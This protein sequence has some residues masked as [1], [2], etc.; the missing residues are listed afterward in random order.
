[1]VWSRA[2]RS[3]LSRQATDLAARGHHRRAYLVLKRLLEIEEKLPRGDSA[4]IHLQLALVAPTPGDAIRHLELAAASGSQETQATAA[5]RIGSTLWRIG[6]PKEGEA[7]LQTAV[8]LRRLLGVQRDLIGALGEHGQVLAVLGRADEAQ[9][10]FE[11]ASRLSR[12]CGDW[13]AELQWGEVWSQTKNLIS[14]G[15]SSPYGY[16]GFDIASAAAHMPEAEL[17]AGLHRLAFGYRQIGESDMAQGAIT[18][19]L[20]LATRSAG[21]AWSAVRNQQAAVDFEFGRVDCALSGHREAH[22]LADQSGLHAQG[23]KF[24]AD[25][26]FVEN[27]SRASSARDT[28]TELSRK[29]RAADARGLA[30]WAE[31]CLAKHAIASGD[32]N[33]ARQHLGAAVDYATAAND[34]RALA[35]AAYAAAV[36]AGAVGE[37]KIAGLADLAVRSNAAA[38]RYAEREFATAT[39]GDLLEELRLPSRR[40]SPDIA[41]RCAEAAAAWAVL[42]EPSPTAESGSRTG[43]V[44][45]AMTVESWRTLEQAERLLARRQAS[46]AAAVASAAL[47]SAERQDDHAGVFWLRETLI[48]ALIEMGELARATTEASSLQELAATPIE[49]LAVAKTFALIAEQE[50]RIA[51]GLAELDG[52]INQTATLEPENELLQVIVS[53]RLL[54]AGMLADARGRDF[55]SARSAMDRRTRLTR[56]EADYHWILE[57]TDPS[58]HSARATVWRQRARIAEASGDIDA[59][60][61]YAREALAAIRGTSD[62]VLQGSIFVDCARW[63]RLVDPSPSQRLASRHLFAAAS[64]I[65]ERHGDSRQLARA[66]EHLVGLDHEEGRPTDYDTEVAPLLEKHGDVADIAANMLTKGRVLGGRE[67]AT[68]IAQGVEWLRRSRDVDRLQRA[69]AELAVCAVFGETSEIKATDCTAEIV[70]SVEATLAKQATVEDR[71]R[72]MEQCGDAYGLHALC[73]FLEERPTDSF[74]AAELGRAR[75]LADA[76]AAKADDRSVAELR[77]RQTETITA[78]RAAEMR[79]DTVTVAQLTLTKQQ[80]EH[81]IE[82]AVGRTSVAEPCTWETVHAHLDSQT[83]LLTYTSTQDAILGFCAT[84]EIFMAFNVAETRRTVE[85]RTAEL[86]LAIR[87]RLSRYPHGH[88]LYELLLGPVAQ[89]LGGRDVAVVADGA[90]QQLPWPALLTR[91]PDANEEKFQDHWSEPNDTR[92]G[93]IGLTGDLRHVQPASASM[94][95][96][97]PMMS[98]MGPISFRLTDLPYALHDRAFSSFPSVSAFLAARTRVEKTSVRTALIVADPAVREGETV[99]VT[100]QPTVLRSLQHAASEGREVGRVYEPT[101]PK[102]LPDFYDGKVV[103]A[104]LRQ[105]ATRDEVLRLL[106]EVPPDVL[107]VACHGVADRRDPL[108]SCLVLTGE[109]PQASRLLV[110]DVL[111]LDLRK[112][113]VVLS[114]CDSAAGRLVGGEGIIG[115]ARGFLMAGAPFVCASLWPVVDEEVPDLMVRFHRRLKDGQPAARALRRAQLDW[116]RQRGGRSTAGW[117]VFTVIGA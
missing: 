39:V 102:T 69:L 51:D 30:A 42:L 104:R 44:T 65:F 67:G 87:E 31:R 64:E 76:M 59:A 45:T 50:G 18:H 79:S 71:Q 88:V 97:L 19:A 116:L 9:A 38:E 93:N 83:A 73:L 55:W 8:E 21:G 3:R 11:E 109:G 32:I 29:A 14:S 96:L 20:V 17:V 85:R 41:T 27:H 26:A 61:S 16:V 54:R 37:N 66:R 99:D 100:G 112:T 47:V 35:Q 80:V 68:L 62:E 90:L 52:A 2:Q 114:C 84:N 78:L 23:L 105:A 91:P 101:L 57:A 15:G 74:A 82:D 6:R 46:T 95:D 86:V 10:R 81:A 25:A 40:R 43:G 58:W 70:A 60:A 89:A 117:A 106:N 4:T 5:Q 110:A 115:L 77:R 24:L 75:A 53:V 48:A 63:L 1:M 34:P 33:A 12:V 49:R 72:L 36:V 94:R 7:C 108:L 92:R 28:L 113:R 111:D 107:H 56:A 13:R 103:T 98:A 22:L